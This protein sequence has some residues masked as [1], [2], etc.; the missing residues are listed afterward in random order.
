ML[1]AGKEGG[2]SDSP[3]SSPSLLCRPVPA[4]PFPQAPPQVSETS[5][6]EGSSGP[7]RTVAYGETCLGHTFCRTYLLW[8]L[9]GLALDA[10]LFPGW[11]CWSLRGSRCLIQQAPSVQCLPKST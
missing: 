7:W 3:L 10:E 1:I 4:V 11:S 6:D 2:A 8:R 9:A 5:K